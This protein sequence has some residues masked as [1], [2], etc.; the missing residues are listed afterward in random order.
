MLGRLSVSLFSC[1]E[2]LHLHSYKKSQSYTAESESKPK[3]CSSTNGYATS[4]LH[5]SFNLNCVVSIYLHLLIFFFSYFSLL[6]LDMVN[7]SYLYYTLMDYLL[8]FL[9]WALVNNQWSLLLDRIMVQEELPIFLCW[10]FF[11]WAKH[12]LWIWCLSLIFSLP[13]LFY[14]TSDSV[15][16]IN[17]PHQKAGLLMILLLSITNETWLDLEH[18]LFWSCCWNLLTRLG[19]LTS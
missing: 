9:Y 14:S 2:K 19:Y 12:N 13:Q 6:K 8:Y 1:V 10:L 15:S 7:C 3:Q 17:L 18:P 16:K 5:N 4:S 11:L